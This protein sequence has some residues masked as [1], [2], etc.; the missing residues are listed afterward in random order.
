M[1]TK[2]EAEKVAFQRAQG[3]AVVT[4]I[5]MG[6]VVYWLTK[7]IDSLQG[8]TIKDLLRFGLYIAA[9]FAVFTVRPMTDFYQA[10]I[11]RYRR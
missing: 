5:C 4:F 2:R 3:L 9:F 10:A 6:I 1:K 8:G 11:A 7:S